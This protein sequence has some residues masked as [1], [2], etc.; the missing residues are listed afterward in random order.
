[1]I[2][3]TEKAE[4]GAKASKR[5]NAYWLGATKKGKS[6]VWINNNKKVA[7]ARWA[8]GYP[9]SKKRKS[10]CAA[11]YT[12]KNEMKNH[13][14]KKR[15]KFVCEKKTAKK[16]VVKSKFKAIDK[17]WKNVV[18]AVGGC[19]LLVC[20]ILMCKCCCCKGSDSSLRKVEVGG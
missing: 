5:V 9:K 17:K 7:K 3:T 16:P 12:D 18:A 4:F 20:L 6:W 19:V 14:C 8:K 13:G 1:M 10:K 2:Q 11:F 15:L